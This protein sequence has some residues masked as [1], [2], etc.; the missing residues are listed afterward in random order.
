MKLVDVEYTF[1]V[2]KIIFFFTAEVGLTFR[3]W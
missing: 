1:D 2:S 3:I